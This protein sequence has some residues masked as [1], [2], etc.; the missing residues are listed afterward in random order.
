MKVEAAATTNVVVYGQFKK[1]ICG[2]RCGHATHSSKTNATLGGVQLAREAAIVDAAR[3][4]RGRVGRRA[5][6]S[7][8]DVDSASADASAAAAQSRPTSVHTLRIEEEASR[9]R[10]RHL[11]CGHVD[12]VNYQLKHGYHHSA[13]RSK[14]QQQ[15]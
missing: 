8:L 15:Y 13:H 5:A 10:A 12:H 14:Q 11:Q 6:A 4:E 3:G 9:C 1:V 7:Q 2:V